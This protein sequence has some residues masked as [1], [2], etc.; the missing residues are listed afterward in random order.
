MEG[1]EAQRGWQ[2]EREERNKEAGSEERGEEVRGGREMSKG[3]AR[4]EKS[5]VTGGCE[6]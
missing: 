6:R 1:E 3:E 2:R 4:G 5:Q